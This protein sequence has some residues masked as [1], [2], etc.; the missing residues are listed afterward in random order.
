[1]VWKH[2]LCIYYKAV[3]VL[4]HE[5]NEQDLEISWTVPDAIRGKIPILS[6]LAEELALVEGVPCLPDV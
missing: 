6:F 2:C 3:E 1:M 5:G 4:K